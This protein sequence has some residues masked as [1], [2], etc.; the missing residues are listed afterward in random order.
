[1]LTC[2]RG[3]C[4]ARDPVHAEKESHATQNVANESQPGVGVPA[5]HHGAE[6]LRGVNYIANNGST[7]GF[8]YKTDH[9]KKKMR[10]DGRSEPEGSAVT[11]V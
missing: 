8:T 3:S 5:S 2:P 1:M 9:R 11:E 6:R 10:G 7:I 4:L